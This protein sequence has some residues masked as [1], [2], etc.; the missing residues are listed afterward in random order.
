[1]KI[2][3][4]WLSRCV[5]LVLVGMLRCLYG[6][7]RVRAVECESFSSPYFLRSADQPERFLYCIWH[8]ILL[9]AIFSGRPRHMAG[10]VSRHQDGGYLADGMEAMGIKTIRGSS[11][12]GGVQALKQ[13]LEAAQEYHV[14]ITPDGPRGPRHQMKDG[15]VFMASVSGRR[16][17]PVAS[18]CR[19]YWR[20]QGSWTDM[21]V[22]KPF[23]QILIKAGEPVSIP[24]N[25]TREEITTWVQELE[26]RM[27][28]LTLEVE[29]E[30]QAGQ[31][32]TQQPANTSATPNS[33]STQDRQAA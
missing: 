15:I 16:I 28:A 11:K 1:M 10:L 23:T 25:L 24:P 9:M 33:D 4:R 12:R 30:L 27:A 32:A 19:R 22:P 2:R 13:C 21:L 7:C 31:P 5:S 3:S 26:R 18:A 17:V 20:I 14:S 29:Q 8:D 6:T